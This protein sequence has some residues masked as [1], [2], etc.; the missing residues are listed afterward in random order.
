MLVRL[1]TLVL[2]GHG[3]LLTLHHCST[4][5]VRQIVTIILS[6]RSTFNLAGRKNKALLIKRSPAVKLDFIYLSFPCYLF[7]CYFLTSS[8]SRSL[9]PPGQRPSVQ[10]RSA[11]PW[12]PPHPYTRR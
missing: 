10:R 3:N 7:P 9:L 12:S 4:F 6:S 5:Q 11:G 1:L 2:T 8:S